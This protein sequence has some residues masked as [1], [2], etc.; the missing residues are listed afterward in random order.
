MDLRSHR[1]HRSP[2]LELDALMALMQDNPDI[3]EELLAA[4]S[5]QELRASLQR[6]GLPLE[7]TLS[8]LDPEQL[9]DAFRAG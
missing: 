6:L 3:R 7:G 9:R 8:A 4:S 1:P 5:H 2:D